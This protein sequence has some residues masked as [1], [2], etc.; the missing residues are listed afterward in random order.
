MLPPIDIAHVA[1]EARRLC[2]ELAERCDDARADAGA[3][4]GAEGGAA[5]V[6]DP[7]DLCDALQRVLAALA[8]IGS[9]AAVPSRELLLHSRHV[10]RPWRPDPALPPPSMES[11][12][13]RHSPIPGQPPQADPASGQC[14]A[15]TPDLGNLGDHGI[16]LLARLAA[17]AGRLRLPQHARQVEGLALPLACWIARRG[18]ELGHPAP[19]VNAA[20]ALANSLKA[21]DDLAT[22]CGLMSEVVDAL[23]P[24]VTQDRDAADSTRPWRVL[25]L[26][27]AIVATRSN[28]PDLMEPAF[29][30]VGEALPGDAPEFFREAMGQMEALNYP[31]QVRAVVQRFVD[32]WCERRTLH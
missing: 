25:L 21:P 2:E 27:R 32:A 5:A 19:V 12:L 30:A 6:L 20:G 1:L 29:A 26:N 4:G 3:E 15:G 9:S 18:G 23:S 31:P 13:P 17:L 11:Y 16:D 10:G 14:E 24:Q 28:R 7:V 8:A 22:L